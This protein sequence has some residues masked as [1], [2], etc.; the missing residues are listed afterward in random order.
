MTHDEV[1]QIEKQSQIEHE[2]EE[3]KKPYKH[4]STVGDASESGLIKFFQPI[5]DI[6]QTR[7]ENPIIQSE[8][9][10][11]IEIPFNST[12]K[13]QLSIHKQHES[14]NDKRLLLL[15]KG[16]PEIVFK[17]SSHIIMD[18]NPVEKTDE[19][20]SKYEAANKAC[21]NRG[22]RVLGFATL[23]LPENE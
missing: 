22:E 13:F 21:A 2:K 4:R 16:A 5:K 10:N 15:M 17:R 20:V 1:N 23:L 7:L 9:G 8:K 11:K 3:R 14:F 18:G 6:S 12:I 19:L